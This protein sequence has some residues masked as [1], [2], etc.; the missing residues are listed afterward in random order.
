MCQGDFTVEYAGQLRTPS[1]NFI[2][3]LVE[4]HSYCRQ[5]NTYFSNF[6]NIRIPDQYNV[7]MTFT[8]LL[9][10]NFNNFLYSYW[11]NSPIQK[12]YGKF[13][14]QK[15]IAGEFMDGALSAVSQLA[16]E[17][18]EQVAKTTRDLQEES[19]YHN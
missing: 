5:T 6:D 10:N 14:V 13:M 1:A 4:K 18:N 7:K 15:G 3:R 11:Y 16:D 9:P 12:Q 2:S 8:S 19:G 17:F